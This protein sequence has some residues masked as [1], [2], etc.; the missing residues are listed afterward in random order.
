MKANMAH[1]AMVLLCTA[2]VLTL[3]T[4]LAT[5]T[6]LKASGY[7]IRHVTCTEGVD[8]VTEIGGSCYTYYGP[9]YH[10]VGCL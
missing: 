5:Q 9:S 10:G 2:N 7:Y 4:G 3:V 8:C 6:N 1:H